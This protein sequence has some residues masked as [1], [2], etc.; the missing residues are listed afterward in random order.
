MTR[1]GVGSAWRGDCPGPRRVHLSDR[2]FD[3]MWHHRFDRC[4]HCA[5]AARPFVSQAHLYGCVFNV[6]DETGPEVGI[7]SQGGPPKVGVIWCLLCTST[8]DTA[9][10]ITRFPYGANR[11]PDTK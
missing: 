2:R 4:V 10:K 9:K 8:C 7:N 11:K 6:L 3:Y 1:P 5:S